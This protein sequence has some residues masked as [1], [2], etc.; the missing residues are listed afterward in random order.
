MVDDVERAFIE[1]IQRDP[2]DDEARTVY[3]DWLEQRGDPR[4]EYVRLEALQYTLPR[5]LAELEATLD[6]AWLVTVGRR[7][8][9]VLVKLPA[10]KI[11]IIKIVRGVTGFGL[12]DAM[13]LV[14]SASERR[15]AVIA[16]DLDRAAADRVLRSFGE[17]A[18]YLR[19]ESYV[20]PPV[21]Q[22]V[23]IVL[24]RVH[25]QQEIAAIK[26]VR[27][28]TGRG[29]GQCRDIVRAAQQGHAFVLR[30]EINPGEAE[31]I[32]AAFRGIGELRIDTVLRR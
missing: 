7:Y 29:V 28:V 27:E 21:R 22:C 20:G 1:A 13:Q 23:R 4:G 32:T 19:I 30:D 10:N 17:L 5:R 8:R 3:A 18:D 12:S 14:E 16:E 31:G 26:A 6:P 25:D 11:G 15:P 24:L 2:E 9:V